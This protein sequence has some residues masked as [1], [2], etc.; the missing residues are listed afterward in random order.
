MGFST[1][2]VAM[3]VSEQTVKL[4]KYA[5]A[6]SRLPPPGCG[7]G[8][9]R[10]LL[11][12]A[13]YAVAFGVAEEQFVGDVLRSIPAGQRAVTRIEIV[14]AFRKALHD[15]GVPPDSAICSVLPRVTPE[16]LT[17]L[18]RQGEG[19]TVAD[20]M[21]SSPITIPEDPCDQQR[22][23]LEALY[24]PSEMLFIGERYGSD[25]RSAQEWVRLI[26]DKGPQGPHII[27]NTL[28]GDFGET[29]DGKPSRRA[30]SCVAS[31]R[32]ATIEFDNLSTDEQLAF[33]ASVRLPV[34]VL[35]VSGNKSIHGWIRV[36]TP[37]RESWERDVECELFGARLVPLGVDA[38]CRNEARLSRIPGYTRQDSGRCQTLLYLA[39]E[40]RAVSL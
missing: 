24:R 40:G 36:N 14:G 19:A 26:T 16:L 28:T 35:V 3:S 27:P 12:V 5:N 30:D 10:A 31:Y 11:G 15:K 1:Q 38:S 13:N 37:D 17:R 23:V 20:I 21:R 22:I 33:W 32:F 8:A 29:K 9:H 6:I 25:I 39:P 34:S 7:Q 4:G 2:A 18:I